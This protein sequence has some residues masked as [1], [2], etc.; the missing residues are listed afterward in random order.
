MKK[1]LF[2]LLALLLGNASASWA[3]SPIEIGEAVKQRL[4]KA[5]ISGAGG[6]NGKSLAIEV[7]NISGKPL[8]LRLEAGRIFENSDSA[9]QNLILMESVTWK[10]QPNEQKKAQLWGMCTESHDACPR[11]KQA[12]SLGKM[13]TGEMQELAQL[14]ATKSYQSSTIQSAVWA[15]ANGNPIDDIYGSDT[16]MMHQVARIVSKAVGKP[17]AQF[18]LTPRPHHITYINSSIEYVI[19]ENMPNASLAV[20]D[21]AGNK[22]RGYFEQQALERGFRQFKFSMN[23]SKEG[24]Y[25]LYVRLKNGN[26]VL[27]EREIRT[28]DSIPDLDTLH[29]QATF[30]YEVKQPITNA[31]VGIFDEAGNC[32]FVIEGNKTLNVGYQRGTYTAKYNVLKGKK[33]FLQIR[34]ASGHIIQSEEVKKGQKPQE[35]FAKA[36]VTGTYNYQLDTR[37]EDAM[38]AIY[39][40]NGERI[41]VMFDHSTLNPGSKS[42]SYWFDHFQGPDMKFYIRLTD[43]TGKMVRE[44]CVTCKK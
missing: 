13:S 10:L 15:I 27:F 9:H 37:L 24:R 2:F 43:A 38:M 35:T 26:K 29:Y 32:Y 34:D 36:R 33:Y 21:S 6:F 28:T 16:A 42:V 19:P 4:L 7:Q 25:P 11:P 31:T 30:S 14:T 23:H 39:N 41:R 1:Q 5:I 18:H 22:V 12:F 44:Q 8:V 3:Q 20:Y 40:E 17:I